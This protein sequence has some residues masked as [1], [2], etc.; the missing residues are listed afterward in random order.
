MHLHTRAQIELH[1]ALVN[2]APGGGQ[3]R[4]LPQIAQPIRA[5]QAF[6]IE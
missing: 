5:D 1:H 6:G 3:A 4:H 2:A